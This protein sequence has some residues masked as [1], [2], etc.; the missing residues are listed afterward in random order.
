[1]KVIQQSTELKA[2]QQQVES[3]ICNAKS[4][5]QKKQIQ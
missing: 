1:M 2:F 4:T 3:L 5:F